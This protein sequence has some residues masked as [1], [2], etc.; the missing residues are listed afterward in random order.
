[1]YSMY[2]L[3]RFHGRSRPGAALLR[4]EDRQVEYGEMLARVDTVRAQLLDA[5]I[6]PGHRVAVCC[7][8]SDDYVA[9]LIAVWSIGA[10]AAPIEPQLEHAM[11][12]TLLEVSRANWRVEIAADGA[13]VPTVTALEPPD[14][15]PW[16]PGAEAPA[17]LLFTSGSS[18]KP[19]AVMLTQESLLAASLE[20]A[21]SVNLTA[22]DVQLT[23]VPFWHAYGQNRGLNATLYAGACIAPVFDDDLSKRLAALARIEPTV[24]L[25]MASF[26]GFLA[27]AKRPLGSRI[28]VA[29]SGAAPLPEPIKE[30]FERLYGIPL[31]RTYGLT[32]FLLISCERLGERRAPHGVGYPARGVEV[33][34]VGDGDTP[35]GDPDA[36][37]RILV[38]G[39]PAM[40]GY[41]GRPDKRITDDGWLDTEDIGVLNDDGLRVLGRASS[42]VKRSGY[43]VY[44]VEVQTVL[45]S[46]PDVIDVAVA[47][48]NSAFGTEELAAQVV[49]RDKTQIDADALL[50]FCRERMPDYKV[51]SRCTI[52][53]AVTKLPSGKPDLVRITRDATHA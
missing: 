48:F 22:A 4:L 26:Y 9:A 27:F 13:Q 2:D 25:S 28:R 39:C 14:A 7:A 31:L 40:Q 42:F 35:L 29:V 46:H 15:A 41:L 43:K 18:G 16:Y 3:L 1:M 44:P 21:N 30:R 23:T 53:D 20:C 50:Q 33:R 34:I 38:R 17:Q 8:E 5:G 52:V 6:R 32:E 10:T 45:A 12:Q 49:V 36:A 11:Q 19:K 51:P 47:P 37:G 24:L